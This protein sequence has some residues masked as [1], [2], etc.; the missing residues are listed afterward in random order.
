[1]EITFILKALAGLVVILA[2]LVVLFIY[3]KKKKGTKEKAKKV[4]KQRE[5]LPEYSLADILAVVKEKK[6]SVEE[7][8][9]AI[10]A[11]IRYHSKIPDKL[12][13]RAHSDFDIYEE[14]ILRLCHHPKTSKEI[15]LKLDRA[16]QKQ[17][18]KYAREL[19]NALSKGLNARG[20]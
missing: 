8:D 14:I 7:L 17:N 1:M 4:A 10:D 15:I 3:P 20:M 2:F 9:K 11:L 12:G 5:K 13:M 16:L 18:P 19:N 6:S